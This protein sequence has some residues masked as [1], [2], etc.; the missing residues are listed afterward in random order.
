MDPFL[1]RRTNTG[2][3]DNLHRVMLGLYW[4]CIGVILGLYWGLESRDFLGSGTVAGRNLG[5]IAL[6][7]IGFCSAGGFT[8]VLPG[9]M[10]CLTAPLYT[11]PPQTFGFVRLIQGCLTKTVW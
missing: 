5:L 7:E 2:V 4:G 1:R 10:G 3:P 6:W 9:I 11:T 8:C